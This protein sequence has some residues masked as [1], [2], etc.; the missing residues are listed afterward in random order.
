MK[1]ATVALLSA[2]GVPAA[3]SG[4]EAGEVYSAAM[5]EMSFFRPRQEAFYLVR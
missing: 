4:R 2:L 3:R 1:T 5:A